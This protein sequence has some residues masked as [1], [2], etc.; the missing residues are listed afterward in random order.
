MS[1][2]KTTVIEN[3]TTKVPITPTMLSLC[4]TIWGA[5]KNF[6]LKLTTEDKTEKEPKYVA[7]LRW[8]RAGDENGPILLNTEKLNNQEEAV[9]KLER[10]VE[11]FLTLKN[12]G[13]KGVVAVVKAG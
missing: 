7:A 4:H 11:E 13:K 3:T 9:P 10:M 1:A 12:R 8:V 6:S 2:I 5:K